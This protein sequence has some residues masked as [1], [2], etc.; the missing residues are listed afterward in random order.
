MTDSAPLI[1]LVTRKGAAPVAS[2]GTTGHSG[3]STVNVAGC[4]GDLIGAASACPLIPR[5][6]APTRAARA[7]GRWTRTED[8]QSGRRTEEVAWLVVGVSYWS[9]EAATA[10]GLLQQVALFR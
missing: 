6:P 3:Q 10:M 4:C 9:Y 2:S 8:S 5:T 7:T 1:V